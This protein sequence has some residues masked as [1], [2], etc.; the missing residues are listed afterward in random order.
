MRHTA[1]TTAKWIWKNRHTLGGRVKVLEFTNESPHERM[2]QGADY[3]NALRTAKAIK[4]LQDL[5]VAYRC[6]GIR[7]IAEVVE[8]DRD[9]RKEGAVRENLY[10]KNGVVKF[11]DLRAQKFIEA[12]LTDVAD[13]GG[14]SDTE[15]LTF[16]ETN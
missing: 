3:T 10:L 6:S 14:V 5:V 2:S 15:R 11:N 9:A 13:I 7:R 1:K 16:P 8:F 12:W 4:T